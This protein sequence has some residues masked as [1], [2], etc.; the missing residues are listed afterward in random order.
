MQKTW[1]YM[2]CLYVDQIIYMNTN[3][4]PSKIRYF[5]FQGNH[6]ELIRHYDVQFGN[7][8]N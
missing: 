5:R 2:V 3:Q 4:Y 8:K 1:C 7:K 6:L